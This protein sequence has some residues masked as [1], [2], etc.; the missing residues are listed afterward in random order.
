ML[1]YR[2][3]RKLRPNLT[4]NTCL[5]AAIIL[6][7]NLVLKGEQGKVNWN[8]FRGP[9]SQGIAESAR[10]PVDFGPDSNV[11]WKSVIGA[12]HSSPVIWNNRIFL[13]AYDSANK[14][15]LITLGIDREDGKILWRQVV[16][17]ETQIRFHPLNNP[18]SCTPAADEKHVYVYFGTYGL[19]CYDHAGKKIWQRKIEAPKS[20]YGMATSPIL[21]ENKVIMVL[22]GDGGSSRLLAVNRDTGETVWEQ[23]R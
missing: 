23:P 7:F 22:D 17:A 2:L 1:F 14:K 4:A 6:L 20:K 21:H 12:G 8:Q 18:A 9:N 19:L 13:T 5:C 15:E 16:Q 3:S 10:I 11:L